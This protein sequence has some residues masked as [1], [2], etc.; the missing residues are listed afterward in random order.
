MGIK[1]AD[2]YMSFAVM[3]MVAGAALD[4]WWIILA[5]YLC[6]IMV[7]PWGKTRK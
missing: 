2:I 6:F 4:N 7:I 3:V 5:A 1:R